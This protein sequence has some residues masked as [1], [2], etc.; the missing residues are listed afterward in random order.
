M[1]AT[2]TKHKTFVSRKDLQETVGD[3]DSKI[4]VDYLRQELKHFAQERD[5]DQVGRQTD[6]SGH[7]FRLWEE[8]I[9]EN[10]LCLMQ[11]HTPRNLLLA[12]VG[13]VS[14][15]SA[16]CRTTCM[17]TNLCLSTGRRT[18]RGKKPLIF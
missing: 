1:S 8:Q 17:F 9:D 3:F 6:S 2:S 12:L 11:F 10:D 15:V 13:E 7:Y 5:W 16:S 14:A 18:C 4:T